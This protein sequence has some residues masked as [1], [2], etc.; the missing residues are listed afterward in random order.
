MGHD[1]FI[2]QP[3]ESCR[4]GEV[5]AE[6]AKRLFDQASFRRKGDLVRGGQA[7]NH[8]MTALRIRTW[9]CRVVGTVLDASEF[10]G[11][12]DVPTGSDRSWLV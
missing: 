1:K 5:A 4:S 7:E 3:G 10:T 12:L 8:C 2:L 9:I 11:Q 6:E